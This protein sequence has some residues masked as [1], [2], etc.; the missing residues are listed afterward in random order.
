MK[1]R[2]AFAKEYRRVPFH[3]NVIQLVQ[4]VGVRVEHP[5]G[6][7]N[8]LEAA[9]KKARCCLSHSRVFK[10]KHSSFRHGAA[11]WL[12]HPVFDLNLGPPF[13]MVPRIM[14]STS[15]ALRQLCFR[16]EFTNITFS[17]CFSIS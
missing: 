7:V 14:Y 16:L 10:E 9:E 8:G 2:C 12:S 13:L 4:N 3:I 15:F 17:V 1:I 6:M 5:P 11:A